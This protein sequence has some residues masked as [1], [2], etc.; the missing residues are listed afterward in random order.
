MYTTL[1]VWS[2]AHAPGTM[3]VLAYLYTR[4]AYDTVYNRRTYFKFTV[5]YLGQYFWPSVY[6]T[7]TLLWYDT[8]YHKLGPDHL[9]PKQYQQL[10]I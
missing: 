7:L 9:L 1:Y 6:D 8:D 3:Y 10:V 4:I 2:G 5:Y